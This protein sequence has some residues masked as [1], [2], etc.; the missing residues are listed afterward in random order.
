MTTLILILA[1]SVVQAAD[2][3]L[4]SV[5]SRVELDIARK[6]VG[7]AYGVV[8]GRFLVELDMVQAQKLEENG[9]KTELIVSGFTKNEYYLIEKESPRASYAVLAIPAEY[10]RGSTYIARIDR[11]S[12][13][14]L[15][16]EGFM[17]RPIGDTQTPLF[18]N[19]APDGNFVI[20]DSYPT[21]TLADLVSQDSLLSYIMRMQQFYTR[22]IGSDSAGPANDWLREKFMELGYTQVSMQGFTTGD[23]WCGSYSGSNIICVKPGTEQPDKHIVVGG[24]FDSI[25][26]PQSCYDAGVF[27]PGADDNGSGVAATLEL[28]RIFA[29]LSNKKTIVFAGFGGEELGLHGANQMAMT[30]YDGGTDVELVVNSDMIGYTDDEE[31][32]FRLIY[33]GNALFR[34]VFVRSVENV[35]GFI[36]D[37]VEGVMSSDDGAFNDWGFYTVGLH[38]GDFNYPGWHTGADQYINMDFD[39]LEKVTEVLVT[40]VAVLDQA[41]EPLE[42][43]IND[44]GDGQSFRI[45]WEDCADC[46]YTLLMGPLPTFLD[47]TVFIPAGT[48]YYDVTGLMAATPY[49]LSVYRIQAGIAQ[50]TYDLSETMTLTV[51]R[52]PAGLLVS[53]DTV[54]VT[55]IWEGNP[56]LDLSHYRIFKK[57]GEGEW[58]LIEDNYTD[59]LYLDTDVVAQ[60]E[61]AYRLCAVDND[62]FISDSSEI[63][64]CWLASFDGGILLV[65]ETQSGGIN[66]SEGAQS[67][68]YRQIM[69]TLNFTTWRID[70]IGDHLG[71]DVMGRYGPTLW[72]DDDNLTHLWPEYIDTMRWYFDYGNDFLFAGWTS[73]SAVT[74][75]AYFHEGDFLYDEFG[76]D[77]AGH[78]ILNR[79]VGALGES[80]WPDLYVRSD[81]PNDGHLNDIQVFGPA[82][83]AEVIYRFDSDPYHS[84]YQD[85]PVGIAYDT[86]DGK[87][88]ILGFPIY[89][90]TQESAQALIIRVMEYF[91][92][93][94]EPPPPV[95]GDVTGDGEVNILDVTYLIQYIYQFGPPPQ[96][97]NHGDPNG[98]CVINILDVVYLIGY[99]YNNGP[100]PIAGCVE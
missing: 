30:L 62:G 67:G 9:V 39:Y 26:Y 94:S 43:T 72:V 13:G 92:A 99:L 7:Y 76:I 15:F 89:W 8:D 71:H 42:I 60:T 47:D 58:Y 83:G 20:L 17:V 37:T 10:A 22:F 87:R 88:V 16:R 98:D 81:A 41:P 59:T 65:D 70:S 57:T 77:Y 66:P 52:P 68:Y 27:A 63:V 49:Y 73:I 46:E 1:I 85:R 4:L 3:Y 90:L 96:E 64:N 93:E 5:Q 18:F 24:H 12:V 45:S 44:F 31:P 79:F 35:A 61:Y 33:N 80:D 34:D 100:D 78:N 2:L 38:E 95:Y 32:D 84:G 36:P 50:L 11:E 69:D 28:A 25:R 97:L 51:P 54:T 21:D 14:I 75:F 40:A 82:E 48:D 23:T 91:A 53:P 86:Y 74:G 6:A 55:L 56:E 19:P 29:N